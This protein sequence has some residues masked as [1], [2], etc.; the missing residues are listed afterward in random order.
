MKLNA[1]RVVDTIKLLILLSCV[2]I[3]LNIICI[4]ADQ[5]QL[6]IPID[7]A[8]IENEKKSAK[9]RNYISDLL[10]L[11]LILPFSSSWQNKIPIVDSNQN[12]GRQN[13]GQRNC[14]SSS[15]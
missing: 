2:A 7:S 5:N 11:A 14:C 6:Q 1:S 3:L 4:L 13:W 12:F 10:P 8:A 9:V 15:T